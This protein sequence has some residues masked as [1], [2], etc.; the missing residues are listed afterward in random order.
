MMPEV[1]ADE[2]VTDPVVA[3]DEEPRDSGVDPES[4]PGMISLPFLPF[5]VFLCCH[6]LT[7]SWFPC[8]LTCHK[9]LTT[10]NHPWTQLFTMLRMSSWR[11]KAFRRSSKKVYSNSL[12]ID[13]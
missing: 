4:S 7:H 1:S 10:L 8:Q 11:Q 3:F 6:S 2:A 12:D 13:F 9:I 5:F